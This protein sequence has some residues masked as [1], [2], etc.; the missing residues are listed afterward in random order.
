[1]QNDLKPPHRWAYWLRTGIPVVTLLGAI[2]LPIAATLVT[3]QML[4][5][6]VNLDNFIQAQSSNPVLWIIDLVSLFLVGLNILSLI[7]ETRQNGK[8]HGLSDQLNQRTN[9]LYD[10]KEMSQRE[11]LERHQAEAT[12][13]RAKREWEATFDAI[14]DL[15]LLTELDRENHSLQ[16]G[17]HQ[18]T[19]HHLY[20]PDR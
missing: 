5:G 11:I 18:K 6:T 8:E 10:L 13:T 19:R 20:R 16:P 3:A 7:N 2:I 12:I 15:I 17:Y 1:M 4:Y 14:S 9:E